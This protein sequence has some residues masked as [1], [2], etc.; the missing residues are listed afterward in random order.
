MTSF[1]L[2]NTSKLIQSI[3]IHQA[4]AGLGLHLLFLVT[5]QTEKEEKNIVN[6]Q[7]ISTLFVFSWFQTVPSTLS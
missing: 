1:I 4:A 5:L 6:R 3:E 7:K 2:E